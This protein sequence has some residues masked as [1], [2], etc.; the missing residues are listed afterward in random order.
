[1]G[2]AAALASPLG[3]ACCTSCLQ[4][5]VR[6]SGSS[7]RTGEA[8]AG[9]WLEACPALVLTRIA[10]AAPAGGPAPSPAPKQKQRRPAVEEALTVNRVLWT[11][12]D[13]KVG[14]PGCLAGWL[15][16]RAVIAAPVLPHGCSDGCPVC[17]T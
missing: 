12:D 6:P 17:S 13:S 2:R 9:A 14:L 10:P 3:A 8:A 16:V 15:S 7:S 4:V 5:W 11:A 1:M